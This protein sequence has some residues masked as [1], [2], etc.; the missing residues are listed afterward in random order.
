V[1]CLLVGWLVCWHFSQG[2]YSCTNIITK[3]QVREE[4]VYSAYISTLLFITKGSQ[5]RDSSRSG[6]RS[7]CRGH[8]GM[9][10]T[11]LLPLTC[12]VCSLIEHK[13][14]SR[15]MAPPTMGPPLLITNWEKTL[16]LDLMDTFP[17]LKLFS[18]ITL[19]CVKLTHITRQYIF[20]LVFL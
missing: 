17:H 14:I 3:K 6:S 1:V 16:K 12:S 5:G 18:V 15:G 7:W 13:T 19:A 4:R 9:F 20:F 2:F 10:L 11:G 8:G